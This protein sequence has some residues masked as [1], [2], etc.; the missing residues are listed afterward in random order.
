MASTDNVGVVVA[1]SVI[2][3]ARVWNRELARYRTLW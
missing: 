1:P 2:L 3:E